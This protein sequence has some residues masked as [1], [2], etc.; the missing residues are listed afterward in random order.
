MVS[1]A[2]LKKENSIDMKSVIKINKNK[3]LK[4][5]LH[6]DWQLYLLLLPGLVL[7]AIFSYGPMYG[8]LY[9]F[10]D[11][12]PYKG[13]FNSPWVGIKH[14]QTFIE[15][16][17]F[18]GLIKN[19]FRIS[20]ASLIFDF[21]TS[22]IL[23]L[24]IN[25]LRHKYFKKAVQTLSYFPHFVSTVV[26]VGML[27]QFTSP[28]TGIINQVIKLLGFQSVNF[29]VEPGWFVPMY[30]L[31]GIWQN[32]GWGS[33]I[34]LAGLS[35]IDPEQY[36]AAIVD[37]ASR[38]KQIIHISIPGILPTIII[39]LIFAIGSLMSVSFEKVLLMYNELTYE[40]SDVLNTY[41]YRTGLKQGQY[42]LSTAV[43]LFQTI[44]NA[45]LVIIANYLSRKHSET[46]LW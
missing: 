22:I 19:T 27:V 29:M 38:I 1:E 28:A 9:A 34:Y 46:S 16:Y 30:V 33:I 35:S 23:A 37:G 6:R 43:G 39:M 13:F 2:G 40:V 45:T 31:L 12:S 15:S 3:S 4:K 8:I 25:E 5:D 26:V 32:I 18:W 11:Y 41:I 10:Q 24:L 21:P 7:V 17:Y 36:E 14:F 20:L 42:S 44:V